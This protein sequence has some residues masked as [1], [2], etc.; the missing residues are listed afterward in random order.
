MDLTHSE[1]KF[2][3]LLL[4]NQI[5]AAVFFPDV[6]ISVKNRADYADGWPEIP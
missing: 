4:K 3:A 5:I 1:G 6:S 2:T